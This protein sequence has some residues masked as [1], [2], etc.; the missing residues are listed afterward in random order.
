MF[1]LTGDI[2][3]AVKFFFGIYKLIVISSINFILWSLNIKG[4]CEDILNRCNTRYVHN[5]VKESTEGKY[6]YYRYDYGDNLPLFK[7][8]KRNAGYIWYRS[9]TRFRL[10]VIYNRFHAATMGRVYD[11]PDRV[12]QSLKLEKLVN[13]TFFGIPI[14]Y[15]H[16]GHNDIL[17]PDHTPM[18]T[19]LQYDR[20]CFFNRALI[21]AVRKFED[22]EYLE[23]LEPGKLEVSAKEF[24]TFNT[25]EEPQKAERLIEEFIDAYKSFSATYEYIKTELRNTKSGKLSYYNRMFKLIDRET[26]VAIKHILDY[27]LDPQW[28]TNYGK[29]STV[30][31]WN[32]KPHE[33]GVNVFLEYNVMA[34][35]IVFDLVYDDSDT[36]P[37]RVYT[38]CLPPPRKTRSELELEYALLVGG[39]YLENYLEN[40]R[41]IPEYLFD[42]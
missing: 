35:E 33:K 8:I 13:K 40:R 5:N 18:L 2:K 21:R 42:A 14:K 28:V 34:N 30:V 3:D 19:G 23:A 12:L 31:P 38:L 6:I 41:K 10:L 25:F 37:R 29:E 39:E 7:R 20:L 15:F 26:Q 16:G 36:E 11:E 24:F 9:Q 22:G 17:N 1:N 27:Q 32:L 4:R